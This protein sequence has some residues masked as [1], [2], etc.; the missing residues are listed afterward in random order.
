MIFAKSLLSAAFFV[1]SVAS[2][3]IP[4]G[5]LNTLNKRETCPAN[6]DDDKSPSCPKNVMSCTSEDVDPCCT[7]KYGLL[8]LS[9]EWISNYGPKEE[10]TLHGLWPDMCNGT[11]LPELG[12]DQTRSVSSAATVVK[13]LD[14]ELFNTMSRIWPSYNGDNDSFWTHEWNKHGTCYTPLDP[15]C[16]PKSQF[17]NGTDV[18]DFF[19]TTIGLRQKYDLY[20]ALKKEGIVPVPAPQGNNTAKTYS[21]D[22]IRNAI[23]NE[24]GQFPNV[25]CLNNTLSE[26]WLYFHVIGKDQFVLIPPT[27]NDTCGSAI[28]YFEKTV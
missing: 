18:T 26:I 11:Y 4:S 10:F 28:N 23:H 5:N 6:Y 1:A 19:K 14:P 22:Q 8:V 20:S 2:L 24:F 12:C 25:N 15:S 3:S 17:K 9:Q 27:A 13:N 21:V 7:P 16:K